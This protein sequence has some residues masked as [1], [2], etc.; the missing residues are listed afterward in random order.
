MRSGLSIIWHR[1][2]AL[3]VT[4][5]K[6]HARPS[7]DVNDRLDIRTLSSYYFAFGQFHSR[8][9]SRAG[10][11]NHRQCLVSVHDTKWTSV[12][13]HTAVRPGTRRLSIRPHRTSFTFVFYPEGGVTSGLRNAANLQFLLESARTSY[14]ANP[15]FFSVGTP[16]GG[17]GRGM[18]IS[19][20]IMH[21]VKPLLPPYAFMF[22]DLAS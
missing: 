14:T 19:R 15:A 18:K 21:R 9:T 10:G 8:C 6:P 7:G 13:T 12:T 5:V 1:W 4:T 3:P 22:C 17:D 16:G 2:H 11:W 20:L